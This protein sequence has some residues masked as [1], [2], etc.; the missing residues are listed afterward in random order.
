MAKR[1]M[2]QLG[3]GT[4]W[5]WETHDRS[6]L[7]YPERRLIMDSAEESESADSSSD[8]ASE[9]S[10]NG[11]GAG[12]LE[13]FFIGSSGNKEKRMVLHPIKSTYAARYSNFDPFA[14]QPLATM[15]TSAM[16]ILCR[17]TTSTLSSPFTELP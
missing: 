10:N 6:C 8:A 1:Q 13:D 3:P 5:D 16:R 12:S 2:L 9:L 11:S 4:G 17:L 7:E 15:D 14:R